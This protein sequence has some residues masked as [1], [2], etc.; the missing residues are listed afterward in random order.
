MKITIA[1]SGAMGSRFGAQLQEAGHDVTLIDWWTE[2][3][4]AIRE[5][6]LII[7]DGEQERT[8]KIAI[9]YPIEVTEVADIVFL[10]TKS[11]GLP[12][13]LEDIQP[14]LGSK[15]KVISLLNGIGHEDIIRKYVDKKNI[16]MG[17]TVFTAHLKGPGQVAF[18]GGGSI[19]IQN[20][21]R[22]E[23]Q[24]KSAREL[25]QVL[26]EA[27][28]NAIYSSDVKFSIWRKATVNGCN[29]AICALLDCNLGQ[30]YSTKQ[31]PE[32]IKTIIEEFVMVAKEKSVEMDVEDLIKHVTEI[33]L[34]ASDHYPSMH[35]DLD[36][37]NRLTEVDYINGA[38]A[39]IAKDYKLR[40][41]YNE[42]ITQ[43]IHVKEQ[44]MNAHE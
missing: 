21:A 20:Y 37:N 32:I 11:M 36:V 44:I 7:D 2:H 16:F 30:F 24:E 31:N 13:M 33:S 18:H 26:D 35:Q 27:G 38:V 34:N 8:V 23:E 4:E 42:C 40:A 28:L 15:T 6:G 14:I 5:N 1:G 22:G 17:V 19:E 10:F 3:I 39:R 41:P 12:K 43:L 25:V 9:H 29:N